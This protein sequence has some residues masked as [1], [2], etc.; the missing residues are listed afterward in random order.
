MKN[1]H[2]FDGE[3]VMIFEVSSQT[4]HPDTPSPKKLYF[5]DREKVNAFLI[6]NNCQRFAEVDAVIE[7]GR[8]HVAGMPVK[9]DLVPVFRVTIG[10]N[11]HA[12]IIFFLKK[13]AVD[14]FCP[15]TD[16]CQ[17]CERLLAEERDGYYFV[18]GKP[19]EIYEMEQD[20]PY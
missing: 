14:E 11:G 10:L 3:K 15:P 12:R 8:Y 7:D 16:V 5:T 20:L 13:D 4:G 1:D 6:A 9:V 17:K 19:I 18:D 2:C